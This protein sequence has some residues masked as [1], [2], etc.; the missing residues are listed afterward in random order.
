MESTLSGGSS[1]S[2]LPKRFEARDLEYKL[3]IASDH[4]TPLSDLSRNCSFQLLHGGPPPGVAVAQRFAK[5]HTEARGDTGYESFFGG[6]MVYCNNSL[7]AAYCVALSRHH[8]RQ[9]D[10]SVHASILDIL[11]RNEVSGESG[12]AALL[13]DRIESDAVTWAKTGSRCLAFL[14]SKPAFGPVLTARGFKLRRPTA[15][16]ASGGLVAEYAIVYAPRRSE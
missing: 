5:N 11:V 2:S 6:R 3:F 9:P 14:T 16:L 12:L 15:D 1:G 4:Y 13:L 8:L 7:V 10:L